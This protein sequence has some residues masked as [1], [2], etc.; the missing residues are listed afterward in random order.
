MIFLVPLFAIILL[1]GSQIIHL[2]NATKGPLYL[3][4]SHLMRSQRESAIRIKKILLLN[5]TVLSLRQEYRAAKAAL[6]AALA[7]GDAPAIYEAKQWLA[8]IHK[9]KI[10]VST[11][12]KSLINSAN[13]DSNLQ[14][15]KMYLDFK[16][17]ES[18]LRKKLNPLWDFELFRIRGFKP[19][20]AIEPDTLDDLP[21]YSLAKNFSHEQTLHAG[22]N[23]SIQFKSEGFRKWIQ[24]ALEKQMACSVSLTP[25]LDVAMSADKY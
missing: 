5:P 15:M 21:V 2:L 18:D 1:A 20:L 3:C 6:A 24:P 22:W 8:S 7:A 11:E 19:T 16:N 4:R 17:F 23:S 12:Q 10:V 25:D 14:Q 13:F 9:R